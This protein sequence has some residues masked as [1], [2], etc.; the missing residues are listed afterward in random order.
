MKVATQMHLT[1]C[2]LCGIAFVPKHHAFSHLT[3]RTV[4]PNHHHHPLSRQHPSPLS[5]AADAEVAAR[6]CRSRRRSARVAGGTGLW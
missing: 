5:S 6:S 1:S 4:G 3:D 2:R